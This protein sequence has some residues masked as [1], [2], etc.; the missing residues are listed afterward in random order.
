MLHPQGRKTFEFVLLLCPCVDL[1]PRRKDPQ[2]DHAW[3]LYC[4]FLNHSL[5]DT[6]MYIRSHIGGVWVHAPHMTSRL[7]VGCIYEQCGHPLWAII[8]LHLS[9]VHACMYEIFHV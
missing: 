3:L 1:E 2:V 4:F 8:I 9:T 5:P 6:V 7:G